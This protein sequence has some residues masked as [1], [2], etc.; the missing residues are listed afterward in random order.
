MARHLANPAPMAL[1]F[2]ALASK[3]SRPWVAVSPKILAFLVWIDI[4]CRF[5]WAEHATLKSTAKG[6]W[7]KVQ[8]DPKDNVFGLKH[9]PEV[10]P[11]VMLMFHCL[12]VE[13]DPAN[14]VAEVGNLN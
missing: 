14:V 9:F 5:D 6:C 13:D 7:A 10:P 12:A 1:Y 4:S 3:S 8:G 2:A 11:I